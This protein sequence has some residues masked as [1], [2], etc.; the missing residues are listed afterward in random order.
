MKHCPIQMCTVCLK[1]SVLFRIKMRATSPK[2]VRRDLM[3]SKHP[4]QLE[5]K[6]SNLGDFNG[7][8][9]TVARKAGNILS[10]VHF[11]ILSNV[12]F[13]YTCGEEV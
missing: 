2:D 7:L 3:E 13:S 9:T 6:K 11:T 10:N 5:V 8:F 1:K 12:H 4:T